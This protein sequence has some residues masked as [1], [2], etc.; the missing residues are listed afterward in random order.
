MF[1]L[2]DFTALV[3]CLS[4]IISLLAY[5]NASRRLE[6]RLVTL[7]VK[8]EHFRFKLGMNILDLDAKLK[9]SPEGQMLNDFPERIHYSKEWDALAITE[10]ETAEL[11]LLNKI[12]VKNWIRD[13]FSQET[14]VEDPFHLTYLE[15]QN[16]LDYFNHQEHL[17]LLAK[18]L[19][20]TIVALRSKVPF[21][22]RIEFWKRDLEFKKGS[23]YRRRQMVKS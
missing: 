4:A 12:H 21:F 20:E 11:A 5:R 22:R 18:E 13:W 19:E 9:L 7:Y 3:A 23:A 15:I 10:D 17:E 2:Q 14:T 1:T 6:D 8:L 16:D